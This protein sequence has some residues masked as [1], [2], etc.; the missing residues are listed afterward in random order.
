[1]ILSRHNH[2]FALITFLALLISVIG[3]IVVYNASV[4]EAFNGFGDKYYF[5]KQQLNWLILGLITYFIVSR[6]N[7]KK[8]KKI[9][10]YFLIFSLITMILVL[11]PGLGMK[12]QGARRW[13]NFGFFS[14]QPSELLKAGLVVYLS[15][16]LET[17]KPMKKFGL[18]LAVCLGLIMLQPDLGTAVVVATLGFGMY[19]L[20]GCKVS[21]IIVIFG[22]LVF[23]ATA[24]IIVSPYRFERLK[25]FLDPTSDPLG[26]SYHINQVLIG[27]G[28]GGLTGVGLGRSR[29]KYAYLPEA[30]TDSIFTIVG[31]EQGFF[32]GVI[33]ILL[34]LSMSIIGFR[35]AGKSGDQF[36]RL[37]ASGVSLLFCAQ[38][39]VNLASMVALIPLTGVPLPL[40]SYGGSSLI[41]TFLSLG[42]LASVAR[43]L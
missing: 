21:Q 29:Q 18:L 8:I 7:P 26:R 22:I 38:T 42:I 15:S 9:A 16:W 10:L 14:F 31:E 41:T 34:L 24:L 30:T 20:S 12:L 19:Y 37:L 28:S 4:V 2:F 5:A 11:I 32:G 36:S 43:Q 23:A 35:V 27:L 39:F 3:L 1:M 40:I 33:L 6:I 25:T 13:I 17:P